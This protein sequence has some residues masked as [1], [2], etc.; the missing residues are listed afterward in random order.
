MSDVELSALKQFLRSAIFARTLADEELA[1][2]ERDTVVRQVPE[3]GH[4][5]L[6]LAQVDYW[7]GVIDGMVKLESVSIDGRTTTLMGVSNGGWFGEGSVLKGGR[8]PYDAIALRACTI[9]LVPRATFEWL[10]GSSLAFNRFLI[11]QLNARLAQFVIRCEHARLHDVSGHVAHCL[12]ELFDP[13][14]YPGA[15]SRIQL[16]QEEMA[17]LVGVSR[18]TVNRALRRLELEGLLSVDYGSIT[19]TDPDA[20]RRY[21][22]LH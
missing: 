17:H 1:R 19:V 2:V 9:A 5:C 22:A 21:G 6:K 3:G 10:L 15:D 14:L 13:R 8:W 7:V 20:L 12:A 16:S 4:I 11:D 18:P